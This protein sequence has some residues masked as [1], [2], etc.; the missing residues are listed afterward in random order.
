MLNPSG[1]AEIFK[2]VNDYKLLL[3]IDGRQ[4]FQQIKNWKSP[5][6]TQERDI[7]KMK[8]ALEHGYSILRIFYF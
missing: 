7:Y 8:L 2:G 4:H 6:E 5:E 3:E 1:L